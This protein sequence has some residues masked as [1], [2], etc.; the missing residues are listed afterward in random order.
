MFAYYFELGLRSLRRNPVLT[1]LM[2]MAIGFGVAASMITWS[3]F[4]AV[5]NNPIPKNLRSCTPR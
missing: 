3:V 2:V 5:S 1:G 4:R